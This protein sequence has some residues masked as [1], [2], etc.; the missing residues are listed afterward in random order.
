MFRLKR[1][2]ILLFV[3]SSVS[4]SFIYADNTSLLN[5]VSAYANAMKGANI[6]PIYYLL[7]NAPLPSN[8]GVVN[9]IYQLINQDTKP[10]YSKLSE[11]PAIA[12]FFID[13]K[14]NCLSLTDL[15]DAIETQAPGLI[16]NIFD[17]PESMNEIIYSQSCQTNA[18]KLQAAMARIAPLQAALMNEIYKQKIPGVYNNSTTGQL[19]TTVQPKPPIPGVFTLGQGTTNPIQIQTVS[20]FNL[21]NLPALIKVSNLN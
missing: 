16:T 11:L 14:V 2:I 17:G 3:V 15:L 13:E 9:S 4:M 20:N 18:Q 19:D 7:Q 8:Y 6:T 12:H 21:I 5:A 1:I 10:S